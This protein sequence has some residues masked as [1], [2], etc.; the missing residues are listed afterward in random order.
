M[1]SIP[2][3][4]WYTLLTIY[5]ILFMKGKQMMTREL[6]FLWLLACLILIPPPE[7]LPR[8]SQ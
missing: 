8:L 4:G 5:I 3:V 6:R 1:K 2:L 7:C